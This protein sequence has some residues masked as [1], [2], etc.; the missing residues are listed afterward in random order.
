ME[1]KY[2]IFIVEDHQLFR[3][4][5]K[6]MLN[7]RG[8]IEII[9]EAEDG[10]EAVRRIRKAKPDM[11]LLDLSM[12]KMG[13]ISVMK[14][15]KRELP[16]TRVLALTIHE[17]DQYILE[18]F[19][20]GVNGYCIKDASREELMLAVDSVLEGKTYISPDVSDQVMDGY[21][22]GRKEL[23]QNSRWET[24]TQRER[25]VLKLL[26]EG[27]TNKEISDFLC[28]S[29]KTVEKHRSNLISKLNLHNIAQ[30][31]VYAIENGLVETKK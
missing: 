26:A 7:Q 4:G 8:D 27:H 22:T 25:E 23:K 15:I 3:E 9:G 20:A 16:E 2:R 13:G 29:V 12:P 10:L 1:K 5:L 14:E 6:S 31:T 19:Q 18:A 24:V 11:V 17:S 21:L 30:L 28:I